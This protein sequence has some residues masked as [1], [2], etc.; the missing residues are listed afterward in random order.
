MTAINIIGTGNVAWHLAYAIN[1]LAHY[2]VQAVAGR[3]KKASKDFK[4]LA[5]NYV[6]I[7]KLIPTDLTIFAVSDDAITSVARQIPYTAGIFVH[8]SGSVAM[9]VLSSFQQY[10]VLYPLQSFTKEDAISFKE[11]PIC[12]EAKNDSD[13]RVLEN[14]GFALSEKVTRISSSDRKQL[15]LA[16][17]FVNNFTHHCYTIAQEL[18]EK[19]KLS[20]ELLKPLLAK[21]AEKSIHGNPELSQ[22]GPAKRNDVETI[23]THL[24]QLEKEEHKEIY[25]AIS[26]AITS[27]YGKKL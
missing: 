16:A 20:F 23:Q 21:T 25:T 12:I 3:S 22:T 27:H 8:T 1:N 9:D 17:I 26:K 4:E 19:N 10:G 14:L 7:D 11:I 18:C 2:R 13:R 5:D 15:H 6:T 24:D